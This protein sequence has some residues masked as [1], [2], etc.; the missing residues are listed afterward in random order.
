[1]VR[2]AGFHEHSCRWALR[3]TVA[4]CTAAEPIAPAW[5]D[6][7]QLLRR[8]DRC[9]RWRAQPGGCR[10]F[11]GFGWLRAAPHASGR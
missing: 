10:V 4:P 1:M 2:L 5:L 6:A 7:G 11:W 3:T 9:V 8:R